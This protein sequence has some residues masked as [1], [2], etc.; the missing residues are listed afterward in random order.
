M[1]FTKINIQD[2]NYELGDFLLIYEKFGQ[3]PNK[4][5]IHDVFDGLSFEKIIEAKNDSKL[6]EYI[7][8]EDDYIINQK[9]LVSIT[10]NIFCS[11]VVVDKQSEQYLVNDVIFF[12]KD[13][14]EEEFIDGIISKIS[15]CVLDYENNTINKFNTLTLTQTSIELDPFYV[16]IESI[17]IE[18]RY[19]ESVIRKIDK[20]QKKI[21]KN[22]KGLSIICGEKGVGKTTIAKH[23]CNKIDRMTIFIPNTMIDI[24]INGPDFKNF[25]KKF[26]K[27]LLV[28]D[29]CEF[30]SNSPLMKMNPFS[31]NVQQLVDGFLSDNLNLQILLIYNELEEDIDET[32]LDCNNLIDVIEVDELEIEVANE[33]SKNLGYNKKWKDSVRLIDVVQNKKADKIEKIGL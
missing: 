15:V 31:N 9:L 25:L 32:I 1:N 18:G 6:T 17:E 8:S 29:D 21:K 23:L 2:D 14:N 12:Y 7:P 24:T 22:P 26:E 5:I 19:N 16:D 4:I 3:R 20:L 11:Y 33:L 10:D 30:L 13:E 28:I 27:V